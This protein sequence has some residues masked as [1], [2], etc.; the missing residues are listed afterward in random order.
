MPTGSN[1]GLWGDKADAALAMLEQA[2]AGAISVSLTGGNV[3][4]TT[5]NNASDQARN[6]TISFTGTPGVTRTV[7]VPDVPKLSLMINS[8]DAAVIVTAG[9]GL[10]A[11]LLKGQVAWV[12]TDGATNAY[13]FVIADVPGKGT[14]AQVYAP[15]SM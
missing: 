12:L 4:L 14:L 2:V 15:E 11:T 10:S 8:T 5:A 13:A 3:A 6:K 7:T 9:A 1:N